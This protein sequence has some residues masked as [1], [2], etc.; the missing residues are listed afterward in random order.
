MKDLELDMQYAK[1]NEAAYLYS[2]LIHP[3]G[4]G[5]PVDL[6]IEINVILSALFNTLKEQDTWLAKCSQV[7]IRSEHTKISLSIPKWR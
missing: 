5:H 4:R 2:Y 6:D 7:S 1:E 3:N